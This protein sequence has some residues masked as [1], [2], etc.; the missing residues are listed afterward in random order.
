MVNME[1]KYFAKFD[2]EG[3][4]ETAAPVFLADDYGGEKKLLADGYIVISEED[5]HY[6]V[7]NMGDG[8]NGTG[9]IRDTETG[10][11]VSAPPYEPTLEEQAEQLAIQY[12]TQIAELKDVLATATLAGDEVTVKEVR[13]EYDEL[14][15]EYQEK[16][17][18]L[19]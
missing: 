8:D 12:S 14:M 7:G 16:L 6:Y 18:A 5:W 1:N 17:E 11:P 3:K 10:K 9:Y 19:Q 2:E 15:A 4:F 13:A